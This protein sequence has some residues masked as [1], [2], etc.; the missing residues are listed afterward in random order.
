MFHRKSRPK[1]VLCSNVVLISLSDTD[2]GRFEFDSLEELSLSAMKSGELGVCQDP[3]WS[4]IWWR[5]KTA[6]KGKRQ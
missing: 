4:C 3:D 2:K 1:C 6:I 5:V